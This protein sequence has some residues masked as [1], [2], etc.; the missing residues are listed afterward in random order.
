MRP[1]AAS[2]HEAEDKIEVEAADQIRS[3]S[4]GKG[5]FN[6]QREIEAMN[7]IEEKVIK[8][9]GETGQIVS[10]PSSSS[11]LSSYPIITKKNRMVGFDGYLK[12]LLDELTGHHCGMRILP[13]VGSLLPEMSMKIRLLC[14]ILMFLLGLL[15]LKNLMRLKFLNEFLNKFLNKKNPI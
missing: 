4:I 14:I 11:S 9:R 3:V 15:F 8:V 1:I 13:I 6:L 7:S 2:A 10:P 5:L 12:Q